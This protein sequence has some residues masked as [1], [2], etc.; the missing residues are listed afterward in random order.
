MKHLPKIAAVVMAV[1]SLVIIFLGAGLMGDAKDLGGFG[2]Y[3]H[4]AYYYDAESAAFGADFY[5]LMYETNDIIVDELSDINSGVSEMVDAQDATVSA[6][7]AAA[8][9]LGKTG[10]AVVLAVGLA[11]LAVAVCKLAAAFKPEEKKE[12]QPPVMPYYPQ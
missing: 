1:I 11:L 7:A 9:L 12:I 8:R 6:I 4:S 5:T 2:S 10:G 3:N